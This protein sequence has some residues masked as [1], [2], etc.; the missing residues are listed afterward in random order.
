MVKIV[1]LNYGR[2]LRDDNNLLTIIIFYAFYNQTQNLQLR[3][4]SNVMP[5]EDRF[6]G[7]VSIWDG[8]TIAHWNFW[9][10]IE[11]CTLLCNK[12]V[13]FV[14]RFLLLCS[15]AIDDHHWFGLRTLCISW[16]SLL[17]LSVY[18]SIGLTEAYGKGGLISES[19]SLWLKCQK[20]VSN[21]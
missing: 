15:S 10:K 6:F 12:Y 14:P 17:Y 3:E 4:N 20:K 5:Y 21:H 2:V 7:L 1:W 11:L 19:F 13:P 18:L 8:N 16:V 9:P